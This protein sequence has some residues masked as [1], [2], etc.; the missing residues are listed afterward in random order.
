MRRSRLHRLFLAGAGALALIGLVLWSSAAPEGA[1]ALFSY[2]SFDDG[3][4]GTM[5]YALYLPPD[6]RKGQIYSLV[7]YLHGARQ[8]GQ[9]GRQQLTDGLAP[10]IAARVRSGKGVGFIALFPQSFSGS[11]TAKSED[12]RLVVKVI[13]SVKQSYPVDPDR[14]YLTGFA[15]GGKGVWSLAAMYPDLWAAIVPVGGR[16]GAGPATSIKHLPCWCFQG[17]SDTG[18]GLDEIRRTMNALRVAGGE[19]RYTEYQGRGTNISLAPYSDPGLFDWMLS[20]R[21]AARDP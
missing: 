11:W 13:A 7:V 16:A 18:P 19:A 1:Y 17:A 21:R 12:G 9:D 6:L 4:L 15:E 8:R 3:Q 2:G 14:V 10:V 5:P 20:Q